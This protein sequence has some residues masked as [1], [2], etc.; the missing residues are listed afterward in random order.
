MRVEYSLART[1][2]GVEHQAV[3]ASA[4]TFGDRHLMRLA[5]H[6][7]EQPVRGFSQ[8]RRI[9]IVLFRYDQYMDGCLRIDITKRNR[10]M[11]LKHALSRQH[12]SG[13]LAEQAIGHALIVAVAPA[14]CE[15]VRT[16]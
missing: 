14:C 12:A 11:T 5:H 6:L 3:P 2:A 10:A 8:R 16:P 1:R 9:P 15:T 13:N 7:G 4:D